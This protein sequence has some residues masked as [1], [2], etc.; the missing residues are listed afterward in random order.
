MAATRTQ[1]AVAN[2]VTHLRDQVE[3]LSDVALRE[4]FGDIPA[5]ANAPDAALMDDVRVADEVCV[6]ELSAL[7]LAGRS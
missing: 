6:R 7:R 4:I 1:T 3:E 5:Y 2:V